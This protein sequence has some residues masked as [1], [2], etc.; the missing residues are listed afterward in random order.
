MDELKREL[1]SNH[2]V[3]PLSKIHSGY[4]RGGR[5]M[6]GLFRFPDTIS[7]HHLHLHVIVRPRLLLKWFKYPPWL[8]LMW[9]SDEKLLREIEELASKGR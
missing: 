3:V 9:K 8:P 6:F 7:V 2:P 4:H 1:L 5:T